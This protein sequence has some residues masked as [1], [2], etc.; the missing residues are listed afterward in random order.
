MPGNRVSSSRSTSGRGGKPPAGK[1]SP[2]QSL[3][4]TVP[5]ALRPVAPFAAWRGHK[6]SPDGTPGLRA[7][8]QA[9]DP[10]SR[11]L[12][13]RWRRL[14]TDRRVPQNALAGRC[15]PRPICRSPAK[16]RIARA[17]HT[18]RNSTGNPGEHRARAFGAVHCPANRRNAVSPAPGV[19]MVASGMC[20]ESENRAPAAHSWQ[21]GRQTPSRQ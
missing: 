13:R 5:P 6:L 21:G 20:S 8:A 2:R 11:I 3:F 7:M 12:R 17:R 4:P 15:C 14:R 9:P 16:S 18:R 10:F 19:H 1:I